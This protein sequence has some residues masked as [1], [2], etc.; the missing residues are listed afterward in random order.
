[1]IN[2]CNDNTNTDLF[3]KEIQ[4]GNSFV[5]IMNKKLGSGAFG[6]I[7]EGYNKKSNEKVAIKVESKKVKT[8]LLMYESKILKLLGDKGKN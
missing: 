6:D 8:P 2:F 1:M 5:M 4:L 3:E 7:F